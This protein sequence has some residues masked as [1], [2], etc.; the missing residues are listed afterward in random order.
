MYSLEGRIWRKYKF[1]PVQN[2]K[3]KSEEKEVN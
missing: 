1:N 2:R 3:K